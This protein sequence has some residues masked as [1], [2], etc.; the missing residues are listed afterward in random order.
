MSTAK[1][2][3]GG[4]IDAAIAEYGG[5]RADWLDLSTGINPNPYPLPSFTSDDWTT[6]PD[7]KAFEDLLRAARDFWKIPNEAGILAAPGA[8]A[9]IA[10]IPALR[11]AGNVRISDRT[12]NEHAAAFKGNGWNLSEKNPTARVIVH[13]NNPDGRLWIDRHGDG[14]VDTGERLGAAEIERIIRLVASHIGQ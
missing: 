2:D 5:T 3:H 12:Y 10:R 13:P 7:D 14:R 6:L 11:P 1:R 9:L 4:G 8:S